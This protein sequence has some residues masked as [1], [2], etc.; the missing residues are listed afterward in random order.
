ME[1]AEQEGEWKGRTG[2][3]CLGNEGLKWIEVY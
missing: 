1:K 3:L 2:R